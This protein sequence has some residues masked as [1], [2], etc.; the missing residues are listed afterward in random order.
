MPLHARSSVDAFV[1]MNWQHSVDWANNMGGTLSTPPR[2]LAVQRD[3]TNSPEYDYCQHLPMAMAMATG[4]RHSISHDP[5]ASGL[6]DLVAAT[7]HSRHSLDYH[8]VEDNIWQRGVSDVAF[9]GGANPPKHAMNA[10]IFQTALDE[11][12]CAT[13]SNTDRTDRPPTL[14]GPATPIKPWGSFGD[15]TAIATDTSDAPDT[16]TATVAAP[17]GSCGSLADVA[18]PARAAAE[19]AHASGSWSGDSCNTEADLDYSAQYSAAVS[20]LDQAIYDRS[21]TGTA[22]TANTTANTSAIKAAIQKHNAN[23]PHAAAH[24]HTTASA[25]SPTAD[26]PVVM[27]RTRPV[28][29][30]TADAE[31][32]ALQMSRRRSSI[33]RISRRWNLDLVD[34]MEITAAFESAQSPPAV[35]DSESGSKKNQKKRF[36]WLANRLSAVF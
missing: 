6:V 21:S 14:W 32:L 18:A 22:A 7:T 13:E 30:R 20:A 31:D 24:G 26:K 15:I 9:M 2:P 3:P 19:T 4:K 11:G 25:P 33:Q 8:V 17:I 36:T 23:T 29:E 35:T 5:T 16:A 10:F 28:L 12:G 34:A 27:R 1:Q